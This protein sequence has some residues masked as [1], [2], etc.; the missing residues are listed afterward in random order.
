MS[1]GAADTVVRVCRVIRATRPARPFARA[2]DVRASRLYDEAGCGRT[3]PLGA[4]FRLLIPR[5]AAAR[6]ACAQ[7]E[8]IGFAGKTEIS[9]EGSVW[10]CRARKIMQVKL[11][12]MRE[13]R[14]QLDSIARG[15]GG[16]YE[17]WEA[18]EVD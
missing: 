2:V 5:E 7:R 10:N 3:E 9:P 12:S 8:G 1:W 16:E 13:L 15:E 4:G 14:Q 18:G 11:E 17:G 6:S